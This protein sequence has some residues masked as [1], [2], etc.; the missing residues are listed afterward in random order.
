[1]SLGVS[2]ARETM[3]GDEDAGRC[4]FPLVAPHH[5]DAQGPSEVDLQRF[6]PVKGLKKKCGLPLLRGSKEHRGSSERSK[7]HPPLPLSQ[8]TATTSRRSVRGH[9]RLLRAS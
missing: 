5:G 8:M 1:M 7:T 2:S 9:L 3:A 6:G 4:W